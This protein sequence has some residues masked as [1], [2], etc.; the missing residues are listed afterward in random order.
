MIFKHISADLEFAVS[1]SNLALIPAKKME[2]VHAAEMVKFSRE[3]ALPFLLGL[4][5]ENSC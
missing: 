2:V 1:N 5:L 3:T 4:V